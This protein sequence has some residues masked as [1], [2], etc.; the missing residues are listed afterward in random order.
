MPS[1]LPLWLL[2]SAVA[3]CSP[4]NQRVRYSGEAAPNDPAPDS[5]GDTVERSVSS[6]PPDGASSA[7]EGSA[8]TSRTPRVAH[9]TA[10]GDL[11]ADWTS[12]PKLVMP[13]PPSAVPPTPWAP[14]ASWRAR[15][16]SRFA[17]GRSHFHLRR[18]W[19]TTPGF[20][21]LPPSNLVLA[22][23]APTGSY[24]VPGEG[25]LGLEQSGVRL[26][27]PWLAAPSFG[28]PFTL[29]EV[30]ASPWTAMTS[31]VSRFGSE[32][33]GE[34]FGTG[35]TFSLPTASPWTSSGS[36]DSMGR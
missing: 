14:G 19:S 36:F 13:R 7:V 21:P 23:W 29:G 27:E 24:E 30:P 16:R 11:D 12:V 15:L 26:A 9:G 20:G 2:A 1:R 28:T 6:T 32:S 31:S 17:M 34:L 33:R 4:A 22:P 3:S 35:S 25:R 10:P 8:I 5:L 18:E